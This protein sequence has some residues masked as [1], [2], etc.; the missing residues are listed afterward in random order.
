STTYGKLS[1]MITFFK[2]SAGVLLISFYSWIFTDVYTSQPDAQ[3]NIAVGEFGS[4]NR[5]GIEGTLHRISVC[6]PLHLHLVRMHNNYEN[7]AYIQIKERDV[8]K[9]EKKEIISKLDDI[10]K[11]AE[12][13]PLSTT[14][15]ECQEAPRG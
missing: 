6:T 10:D 5:A 14:E 8:L 15:S 12:M 13:V 11:R 7:S 3:Y 9:K 4:D 2:S 1:E